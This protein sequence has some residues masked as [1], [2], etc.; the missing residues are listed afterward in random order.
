MHLVSCH[1]KCRVMFASQAFGSLL[2][3]SSLGLL[4]GAIASAS[5]AQASAPP[6]SLCLFRRPRQSTQLGNRSGMRI[7]PNSGQP[8]LAIF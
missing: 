5:F 8:R 3:W 2:R 7:G 6:I 4:S 1:R